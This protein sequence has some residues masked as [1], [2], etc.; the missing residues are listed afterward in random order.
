[1]RSLRLRLLAWLLP[2]LLV[3]GLAAAAGA[4][5]FMERRLTAAYDLD[6]SDIARALV[7]HL[8]A[9]GELVSLELS[10]LAEVVLRADSSDQIFYA[11]F[12]SRGGLVA[13][14]RALESPPPPSATPGPGP[15]F[16]WGKRK[17]T[18]IRAAALDVDISGVPVT[19]VAAETTHKRD[20]DARDALLSALAPVGLLLTALV[21]AIVFG[22][23][24]GLGPIDRLREDVQT[25]SHQDL[26]P[27]DLREVDT[28]LKPLV[29]ELNAMLSRLEGAR[30]TQ[31][32][33]VA[34]AAHQLRTPIAAIITLLEL[35]KTDDQGRETHLAHAREGAA[36]LARLAQQLLSLAAAD[37]ISNPQVRDEA[38][39]LADVV[40]NRADMWL[41]SATARG[42]DLEFDLEAAPVRGVPLLVGELAGNLVDNATR[43]G[44]TTVR[45]ATRPDGDRSILEVADDGPGIPASERA[46]IFER[47][48][49]IDR[50]STEGSGLGLAIVREIAQRHRAEVELSDAGNGGG[51]E[52]TVSFP[53]A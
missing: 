40:K 18:D 37:P 3:V 21:I 36:R 13:G 8:R 41:R 27:V 12:D 14:D 35:A 52:V 17:Q 9:R 10:E 53:S 1:M 33:F 4:Y 47:F 25:R 44:A 30:N 29:Q 5:I 48:Q 39:D 7:P 42:V 23:R 24:R 32:R 51:T 28:E 2:P 31:A 34:N 16:W 46:R 45:I 20:R 15:R 19:V 43:Y 22:V 50:E 38:V 49:R 26:R 11:V 6:L